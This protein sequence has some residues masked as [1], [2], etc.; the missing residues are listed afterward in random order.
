MWVELGTTSSTLKYAAPLF[1]CGSSAGE[2]APQSLSTTPVRSHQEPIQ[3]PLS[4][5]FVLK[6]VSLK[7]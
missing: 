2:D 6:G 4:S 1:L 7:H 3:H 5:V